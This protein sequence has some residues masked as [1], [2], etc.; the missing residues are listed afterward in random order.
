MN[1][2]TKRILVALLALLLAPLTGLVSGDT[3]GSK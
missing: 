2:T 1:G 3:L